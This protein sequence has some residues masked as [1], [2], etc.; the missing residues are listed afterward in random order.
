MLGRRVF[1]LYRQGVEG[2]VLYQT[3][4]GVERDELADLLPILGDPNALEEYLSDPERITRWPIT[5][6]NAFYGIDNHSA[7]G[8]GFR[9]WTDEPRL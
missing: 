9:I 3:D 2:V 7:L 8:G 4:Y 6:Q 1:D 5:Y